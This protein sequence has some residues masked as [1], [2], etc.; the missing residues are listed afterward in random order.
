[1]YSLHN[2]TTFHSNTSFQIRMYTVSG[3]GGLSES[4]WNSSVKS[5]YTQDISKGLDPVIA[6]GYLTAYT[7][8][9]DSGGLRIR[10]Y[11]QGQ[12][13]YIREAAFDNGKGWG[14]GVNPTQGFPQAKS[15]TG[16]AI[17]PFPDTNDQEAKLFYQ[18]MGDKLVSFDYKR[19]STSE[20]SW[21]SQ[22]CGLSSPSP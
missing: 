9:I 18:S 5:W 13:G 1:M 21:Q 14:K 2:P 4:V 20:G 11:Y 10:I 17:V 8:G 15:R 7:W 22:D 16:L 3:S 12:D 19:G 6:G